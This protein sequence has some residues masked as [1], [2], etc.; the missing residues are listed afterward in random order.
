MHKKICYYEKNF[1]HNSGSSLYL[2]RRIITYYGS[3]ILIAIIEQRATDAD[4]H[5]HCQGCSEEPYIYI[6]YQTIKFTFSD[7]VL[8]VKENHFTVAISHGLDYLLIDDG[9]YQ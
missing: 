5:F 4:I 8:V 9:F 7:Q 2:Y 1:V 3:N 6:C